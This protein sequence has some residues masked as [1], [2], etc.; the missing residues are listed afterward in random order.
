VLDAEPLCRACSTEA[1]P[2]GATD[3]DHIV[4]IRDGGTHEMANLQPLCG[5]CHRRKTAH[6]WRERDRIK[7]ES[8]AT[9]G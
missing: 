3:V 5:L 9:N 1:H 2:I 8:G 6:E 7:R 4:P